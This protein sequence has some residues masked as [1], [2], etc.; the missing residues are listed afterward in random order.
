[1]FGRRLE[2]ATVLTPEKPDAVYWSPGVRILHWFTVLVLV[3]QLV[4][5]FGLQ[6]P[7]T[8]MLIWMPWHISLGF[9]LLGLVVLRLAVR[10]LPP[11]RVGSSGRIAT[12][13]HL[14]LYLV[15]MAATLTGWFAFRPA[16]LMPTPLLFG[17][18]PLRP[19]HL[20]FTAPWTSWHK[21]LVWVLIALVAGHVAAAAYHLLA[22]KDRVVQRMLLADGTFSERRPYCSRSQRR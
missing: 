1:M 3:V 18:V 15:L 13:M 20:P 21:V 17:L 6:G 19:I 12:V 4:V 7:G 10:A 9:S 14:A 11:R 5:V 8:A 16:A 22:L 2:T